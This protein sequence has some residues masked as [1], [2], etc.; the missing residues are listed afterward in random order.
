MATALIKSRLNSLIFHVKCLSSYRFI[1]CTLEL[2][3]K[4]LLDPILL[5]LSA[6]LGL[7]AP[8]LLAMKS[9]IFSKG[10][11]G[12]SLIDYESKSSGLVSL[13]VSCSHGKNLYHGQRTVKPPPCNG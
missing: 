12:F 13:G 3:A 7:N 1:G 6:G 10:I 11:F 2:S 4:F 8:E 9:S 5:Y